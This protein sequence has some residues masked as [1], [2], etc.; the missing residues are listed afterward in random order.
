MHRNGILFSLVVC[1]LML[2]NEVFLHADKQIPFQKCITKVAPGSLSSFLNETPSKS[3]TSFVH[4]SLFNN[5]L[6]V[7]ALELVLCCCSATN[8]LA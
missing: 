1:D 5:L 2:P 3:N 7:M 8:Y 6:S 4:K